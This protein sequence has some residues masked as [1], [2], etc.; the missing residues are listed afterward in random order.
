MEEKAGRR[1]LRRV[2]VCRGGIETLGGFSPQE[3]LTIGE[4][5][6]G[7]AALAAGI[8][9]LLSS[10]LRAFGDLHFPF[11]PLGLDLPQSTRLTVRFRVQLDPDLGRD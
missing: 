8:F 1:R 7:H 4:K 10:Q 5:P 9:A 3:I 11:D 2:A 6:E